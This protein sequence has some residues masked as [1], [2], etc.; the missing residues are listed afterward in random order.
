M[1]RQRG[2]GYRSSIFLSP[3]DV[4]VN[5]TPVSGRILEIDYRPGRFLPAYRHDAAADNE[6][7]EI[8][9]DHQG[10][11]V[12]CRQVVGLLARR[13]VCRLVPGMDVTPGQRLGIMKFGSRMDIFLPTDSD[14]H[15]VVGEA[16]RGGETI[17]ARLQP[18]RGAAI[19]DRNQRSPLT[20][21][22][23]FRSFKGGSRNRRFQRGV[24]LL[25][26]LLTVANMF[27]GW[28]C[29]VLAMRGDYV[30]AAPLIGFA[31]VLD[32]L[33]GRI[34][35]LTGATSAFGEQ[36]DSLADVISFGVAPAT[37][38]Y[39]WG[40]E[41]LGRLG[42]AVAFLYVTRHGHATRPVQHPG[43]GGRQTI[44]RRSAEPAGGGGTRRHCLCVPPRRS[45]ARVRRSWQL[46]VVLVFSRADGEPE[47]DSAASTR[48]FQRGAG[49]RS[50]CW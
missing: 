30:T 49:R 9:I 47:F 43:Q 42:G 2:P 11:T 10:R 50:H 34:A 15:V 1:R 38:V 39:A 21:P 13:V 6:R 35:R 8:R 20:W 7:S 37:L 29:I 27:C 18:L 25:P 12:V 28:G 3:L 36:F 23:C 24:F 17:V 45:P 31:M 19:R 48:S 22:K 14:V 4:H 41:P 26:S 5:R 44:L 40:L 32:T 46:L 33:D 16:V